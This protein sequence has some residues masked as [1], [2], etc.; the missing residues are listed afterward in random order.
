L[1][2]TLETSERL[3]DLER[4]L[5]GYFFRVDKGCLINTNRLTAVDF[6]EQK[7]MFPGG[8]YVYMS[9]RGSKRLS[10]RFKGR[11]ENGEEIS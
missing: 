1:N 11:K 5:P 8:D 9:R 7:V 10:E 3:A 6:T 4:R 2:A